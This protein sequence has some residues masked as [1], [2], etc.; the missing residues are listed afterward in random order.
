MSAA[1]LIVE[2]RS[3][4]AAHNQR[5]CLLASLLCKGL[6]LPRF[7][8]DLLLPPRSH[9]HVMEAVGLVISSQYQTLF[10]HLSYWFLSGVV[11]RVS[12]HTT[13]KALYVGQQSRRRSV[14]GGKNRMLGRMT[15]RRGERQRVCNWSWNQVVLIAIWT[16]TF[17]IHGP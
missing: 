12:P 8:T 5:L 11:C 2:A 10:G 4:G 7:R 15:T 6:F 17:R 1:I 14:A 9:M 3:H 13:E 16:H